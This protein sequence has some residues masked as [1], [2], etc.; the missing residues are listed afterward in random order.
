MDITYL[1]IENLGPFLGKNRF[2]LKP[3]LGPDNLK[4]MTLIG[5]HNGAGKTT[6]LESIQIGLHGQRANLQEGNHSKNYNNSIYERIYES[7][8]GERARNASIEM[9]ILVVNRGVETEYQVI[10]SWKCLNGGTVQE[11]LSILQNGEPPGHLSKEMFQDFLNELVPL[12]LAKFF[13]FDGEQIQRI[14]NEN[15]TGT[16][17]MR[18]IREFLG[19]DLIQ[20]LHSDLGHVLRRNGDSKEAEEKDIELDKTDSLLNDLSKQIKDQELSLSV[21]KIKTTEAT[22]NFQQHE[23]KFTAEG[24][25]YANKRTSL[26]RELA[27][28]ES[29]L[30]DARARLSEYAASLFPF[31]IIPTTVKKTLTQLDQDQVRSDSIASSTAIGKRKE[32]LLRRLTEPGFYETHAGMLASEQQ[33]Q[34]SDNV[35]KIIEEEMQ[36]DTDHNR[37]PMHDLSP[38]LRAELRLQLESSLEKIPEEFLKHAKRVQSAER[39]IRN[40]VQDIARIPHEDILAPLINKLA[41]LKEKQLIAQTEYEAS[42]ARFQELLNENA[43]LEAVRAKIDTERNKIKRTDEGM[44]LVAKARIALITFEQELGVRRVRSL[45]EEVTLAFNLLARKSDLCSAIMFDPSNFAA[46]FIG[47]NGRI[48]PKT[49]LSAGEKQIFAMAVLWGLARVSGRRIPIIIDTPLGRM[50][51]MHRNNI[52]SQY[53]PSASHQMIVLSTDT[54]IDRSSYRKLESIISHSYEL[55]YDEEANSTQIYSGYYQRAHAL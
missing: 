14:A 16:E 13:F 21:L 33:Q 4:P 49:R 18:S 36:V 17:L 20:K 34:F 22:E 24:G 52:F 47:K 9:G 50:D 43:R 32:K 51:K 10:R 6:F 26:E 48:I 23:I 42:S 2:E 27:A 11:D 40:I 41:T 15:Q 55:D 8:D 53:F 25:E 38:N 28:K 44:N 30:Q 45:S 3:Q 31:S 1:S 5:G 29:E 37:P 19:L 39:K 35:R 7:P 46:T 54:E 12:H